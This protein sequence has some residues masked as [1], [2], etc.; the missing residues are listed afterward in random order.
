[1]GRSFPGLR[2]NISTSLQARSH[3]L[4]KTVLYP[5]SGKIFLH[6]NRTNLTCRNAFSG[7]EITSAHMN[8][9]LNISVVFAHFKMQF[10]VTYSLKLL[11][12]MYLEIK[13]GIM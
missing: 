3:P 11:I 6:M 2:E 4:T 5:V 8:R 12:F 9:P 1:M 13:K 10:L 7:T